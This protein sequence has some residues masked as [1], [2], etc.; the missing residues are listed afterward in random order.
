[1]SPPDDTPRQRLGLLTPSELAS[2]IDVTV[3]TL[4]EW[5]RLNQGPAYVRAGKNIMYQEADVREWIK[6]S[7]VPSA[8]EVGY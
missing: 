4:R 1:M 7:V 3:N 8:K 2:A 6:R 5:R